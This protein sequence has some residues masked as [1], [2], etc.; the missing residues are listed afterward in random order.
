MTTTTRFQWWT[1]TTVVIGVTT[2]ALALLGLGF[3]E[4]ESGGWVTALSWLIAAVVLLAGVVVLR[5]R[6]VIGS[7]TVIAG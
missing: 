3:G 5:W 7:W 6:P 1:P 4:T 2:M